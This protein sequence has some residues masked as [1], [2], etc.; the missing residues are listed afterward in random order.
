MGSVLVTGATG[1]TGSHLAR[2]LHARG[3]RVRTLVRSGSGAR[4]LERS[5]VKVVRGDVTR[6]SDVECAATGVHTIYHLAALFRTAGHADEEYRAVHVAGTRHVLDAAITHEVGRVVHCSTAGVHGAVR[7]IPGDEDSPFNPGDIYQKTKLEGEEVARAAFQ[8]GVP[9]VVVRPVGI[10]GPGDLRFLKLF[11]AV[12]N[13]R[14]MMFGSG[15]VPYHLTYIDDLV[16]G[17]ILCG[18]K[19]EA[20]GQ[21][22]ILAGCE[23]VALNDLV[24]GVA[25]A[26]GV[27][28]PSGR[29]P[30]WPLLTGASLC[31]ALCRPFNIEP[32]LHKRR[33]EFFV[34]SRAFTSEKA[35]RELGFAPKVPLTEGLRRTA[36]WYFQQGHL[37]RK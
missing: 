4:A 34:H 2:A 25:D 33:A 6:A 29:L 14:F 28:H 9:G 3:Y 15:K 16:D 7:H 35:R 20:L 31:E 19:P 27:P 37:R 26:V 22:Y 18:E 24:R 12:H 30:L 36:E 8:A 21:T 17:L 10:Y 23:Y 5:G 13:R 32:P 11:R 1:F